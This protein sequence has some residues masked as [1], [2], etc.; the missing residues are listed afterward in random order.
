VES[1]PQDTSEFA[2]S[3][4]STAP[5]NAPFNLTTGFSS[6]AQTQSPRRFSVGAASHTGQLHDP[7]RAG[8]GNL[9]LPKSDSD[10]R[11]MPMPSAELMALVEDGGLDVAGLF[12]QLSVPGFMADLQAGTSYG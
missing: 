9:E 11:S 2:S 10:A 5:P 4:V 8:A 12:P 7:S 3:P 6:V 1:P